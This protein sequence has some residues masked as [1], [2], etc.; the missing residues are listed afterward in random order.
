MAT[1]SPFSWA[2]QALPQM[3]V[4]FQPPAWVVDETLNRLVLFLNHVLMSEPEACQRLARQKGQRIEIVWQ[5]MKLQ[6]QPTAAG[7]LERAAFEGFDLRLTATQD[8]PLDIVAAL[9][10]G[11]KPKVRIEGDVQ[12]AAE[13]NWLIDHVRWDAEE[14]LARLVGDAP[15]HTLAQFARKAM[16]ALRSFVAQRAPGTSVGAAV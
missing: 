13:I 6:L 2:A 10:R 15:A 12:L 4:H 14:D 8:S 1:Q 3:A 5:A 16:E 9:A 11:D 7:L